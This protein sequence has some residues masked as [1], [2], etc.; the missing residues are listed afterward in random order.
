ML[1]D[2]TYLHPCSFGRLGLGIVT[3]S[4]G[5]AC[6]GKVWVRVS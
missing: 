5:R 6:F 3:V 1:H 4:Y 2:M